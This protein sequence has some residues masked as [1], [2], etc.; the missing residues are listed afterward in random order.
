MYHSEIDNPAFEKADPCILQALPCAEYFYIF[1]LFCEV[2]IS[3]TNIILNTTLV[4]Y[5]ILEQYTDLAT[6]VSNIQ[7]SK[8]I[9][10]YQ[11]I[12]CVIIRYPIIIFIRVVFPDPLFPIRIVNSPGL[13]SKLISFRAYSFFALISI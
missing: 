2:N 5:I 13:I 11:H 10:I 7:F 4:F 1:R 12:P 8:I 3:I 9:S 6:I